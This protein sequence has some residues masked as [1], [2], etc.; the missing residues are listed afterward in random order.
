MAGS[1][2]LGSQRVCPAIVIGGGSDIKAGLAVD[3]DGKLIWQQTGDVV[4]SGFS[5]VGSYIFEEKFSESSITSADLSSL[6]SISG[7]NACRNMFQDCI[8]LMSVGLGGVKSISGN[9]S[10]YLM[11][12]GCESLNSVDLDKLETI[13][14]N[15]TCFQM[16]SYCESLDSIDLSNLKT[17]SGTSACSGLF[18]GTALTSVVFS[19]L[20]TI[21]GN[22]ACAGMFTSCASLTSLSFPSLKAILNTNSISGL[23]SRCSGVTIHFPSNMEST[24]SGLTGYP[25]FG[26]TNT[27]LLFDLEPT[28]N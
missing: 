24:V 16:F 17:I 4:F 11:F 25:N 13:S 23:V 14:G 5:D 8:L 9:S 20:E 7:T 22:L 10:C 12:A 19:S 15:S 3:Q 26:G 28:E 2:Y 1:L 21:G 27:T 18:Q 6:E